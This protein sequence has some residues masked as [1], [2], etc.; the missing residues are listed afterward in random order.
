MEKNIFAFAAFAALT[1]AAVA[2]V[3]VLVVEGRAKA[4]PLAVTPRMI[5][6]R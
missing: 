5:F 1:F 3:V 6:A 4:K 2:G